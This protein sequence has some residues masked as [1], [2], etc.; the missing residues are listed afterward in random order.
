MV[1]FKWIYKE[2]KWGESL[3]VRELFCTLEDGT[4]LYRSY[5]DQDF[6]IERDGELYN[7]AVDPDG[8]DRVYTET[9]IPIEGKEDINAVT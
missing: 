9:D 4:V 6:M 2:S 1:S 8:F 3:I 5:S 7:D